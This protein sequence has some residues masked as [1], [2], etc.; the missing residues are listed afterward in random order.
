MTRF[1][2]RVSPHLS[3]ST[4]MSFSMP[5]EDQMKEA[6]RRAHAADLLERWID[7]DPAYDDRV[8]DALDRELIHGGLKCEDRNETKS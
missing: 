3:K 2:V 4:S 5:V 1:R 6:T 7:E 8:A